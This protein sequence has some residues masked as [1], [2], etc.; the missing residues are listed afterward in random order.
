MGAAMNG[1]K[2]PFGQSADGR[3]VS[4]D[5]VTRGLDC[6]CF[7]SACSLPLV[8][9]KGE[10][11]QH[12]FAHYTEPENC[13][14]ARETAIHKFAKAIICD[15]LSLRLPDNLDL[16]QM[17]S[18]KS[19]EWLDGIRPDV[20]AQFDEVVA[21]EVFVA[22]RVPVEKIQ[23]LAQRKLATLEIDL[24]SYQNTHKNEEEWC[25]LVLRTAPRF[26][27]FQ[28][29]VVRE[30]IEREAQEAVEREAKQ[31]AERKARIEQE[32]QQ[33]A[34]RREWIEARRREEQEW[35]RLVSESLKSKDER[36]QKKI[37]EQA[38]AEAEYQMY[39][40][41]LNVLEENHYLEGLKICADTEWHL[42]EWE[43]RKREAAARSAV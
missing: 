3:M 37:E 28:P 10:I 40:R 4:I 15:A 11:N 12:H 19:E 24:S 13:A 5:A 30:R 16:G 22:H 39:Q 41:R 35:Q 7:C 18:A 29:A 17:Q 21:I 33:A 31:E 25:D 26:W 6:Q 43:R 2:I 38:A 8:A 14:E 1:V 20:L 23:K 36:R 9:R 27:L 32:V 42:A 34:E